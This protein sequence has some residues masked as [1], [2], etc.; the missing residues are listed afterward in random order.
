M[1][2]ARGYTLLELVVVVALLALATGLVAPAGYRMI[3]TWREADEVEQVMHAIAALSLRARNE[4]RALHLAQADGPRPAGAGEP[5][6]PPTPAAGG[7]AGAAGGPVPLPEGWRLRMQ[8][9]LT[10]RANGACSDAEG[11]LH[12]RRQALPF[13]VEAPFCRVLREAAGSGGT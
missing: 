11:V 1:I 6:T 7:Q 12:T 3:E 13:R 5:A 10:V 9:P 2:P 4:G 8:V